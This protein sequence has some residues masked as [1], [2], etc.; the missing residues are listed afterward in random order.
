MVDSP[1]FYRYALS[2][3]VFASRQFAKD[4]RR[5]LPGKP[6]L[7]LQ[8]PMLFAEWVFAQRHEFAA[9]RVSVSNHKCGILF[10]IASLLIPIVGKQ[11]A[12]G[13]VMAE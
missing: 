11:S 2:N 13:I 5:V 10:F 6:K 8:Q 3:V 1:S 7:A 12:H 4:F 9:S